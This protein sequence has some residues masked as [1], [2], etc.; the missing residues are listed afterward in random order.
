MDNIR[1]SESAD[2]SELEVQCQELR[3][4]LKTWENNFADAHAGKKPSRG[5]IKQNTEI[6]A[7]YKIYNRTRDILDGKQDCRSKREAGSS[8]NRQGKSKYSA[9]RKPAA[10]SQQSS[11][12]PTESLRTP[13]KSQSLPSQKQTNV[14]DP[15]DNMIIESTPPQ[16]YFFKTAIGP[17]PNRD[18]KVL[19]L[20]DL[21]SSGGTPST[22]K[23]KANYHNIGDVHVAQTP[24][25]RNKTGD[26]LDYLGSTPRGR[27]HSRTPAS[28][29]KKFLLSQFFATPISSQFAAIPEVDENGPQEAR[30][31]STPQRTAS[32][33]DSRGENHQNADKAVDETPAFLKRTTSFNHRLQNALNPK[34]NGNPSATVRDF[35]SPEG[36]RKGPRMRTV[37]GKGLSDYLRGL[38]EKE[39][40]QAADEEHVDEEGLEA[41]REIEN[42]EVSAPILATETAPAATEQPQKTWKKKGQ[43]RTTRRVI[44][45]PVAKRVS[46]TAGNEDDLCSEPGSEIEEADELGAGAPLADPTDSS[47]QK[48]NLPPS[49]SSSAYDTDS[50]SLPSDL[51]DFDELG[52]ATSTSTT[53]AKIHPNPHK[54]ESK[55][56]PH[57]DLQDP[58]TKHKKAAKK[59]T[60]KAA[61]EPAKKKA[62]TINPNA[63]SHMNFRTL[64]IRNRG[65]KGKGGGRFGRRR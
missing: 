38:K 3:L 17:T 7:K 56:K 33:D 16:P 27:H 42:N 21:L 5:D 13:Q 61:K 34:R 28:E 14:F 29:G 2:R 11:A 10:E 41:L 48:E 62:R 43:K 31:V 6:A 63:T 47:T 30:I 18:G 52:P 23:R 25:K 4:V 46:K 57:T 19:G 15:S 45:R 49:P 8:R 53:K 39:D 9:S 54:S 64:K 12:F 26:L 58:A 44:M 24:T 22:R 20:F 51:S 36:M 35:T 65:S 40:S 37:K 50:L 60:K 59:A 32:A 55:A 1:V